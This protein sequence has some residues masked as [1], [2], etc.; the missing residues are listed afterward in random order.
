MWWVMMLNSTLQWGF[1]E[2]VSGNS[3]WISSCAFPSQRQEWWTPAWVRASFAAKCCWRPF[4]VPPWPSMKESCKST[5]SCASDAEPGEEENGF[6]RNVFFFCFGWFYQLYGWLYHIHITL[7]I[8]WMF[9]APIVTQSRKLVVGSMYRWRKNWTSNSAAA[10]VFRAL[11]S[12]NPSDAGW[13][14][15]RPNSTKR[16]MMVRT[17]ANMFSQMVHFFADLGARMMIVCPDDIYGQWQ[18]Q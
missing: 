13:I 15:W 7:I 1:A 14:L 2:F 10:V 17:Q 5:P 16:H 8:S 9:K 18:W 4:Y 3:I 12:V 6:V 11:F